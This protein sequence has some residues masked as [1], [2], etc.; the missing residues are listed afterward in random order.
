MDGTVVRHRNPFVLSVLECADDVLHRMAC[1][2]SVLF[3]QP[4]LAG[5]KDPTLKERARK[6]KVMMHRGLHKIRRT[7]VA[8]IVRTNPDIRKTLRFLKDRGV[9]VGL[10][11]NG[12][13]QGYGYD[14]LKCFQLEGY[15][16]ACVFAEDI[17]HK[18]PCPDPLLKT[19]DALGR[20]LVPTDVIWVIGDR[21]KDIDAALALR[22]YLVDE[23]AQVADVVPLAYGRLT[24]SYL[25]AMRLGLGAEHYMV[26]FR[27]MLSVLKQCFDKR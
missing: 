12:L 14:I 25:R 4:E 24:S 2:R 5:P 16:Q 8:G 6:S 10:C 9:D 19:L 23:T 11:S 17:R 1:L 26:G 15:F 21:D 22:K 3:G 7:G 18:K 27:D 13:G 20:D